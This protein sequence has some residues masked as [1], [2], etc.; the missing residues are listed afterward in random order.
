M[1]IGITAEWN[2]FHSGH[3][4]M[5]ASLASKYSG[6][7]KTAL[8][9]GA[10][11]QRGEPA[12]FDKWLRASWAVMAGVD[13]VIEFPV[14]GVLQS[15]DRFTDSAVQYL[16]HLGC[17]HI[18]FGTE[19]LDAHALEEAAD[20][21]LS[22]KYEGCFQ[23][24]LKK[25]L[26]YSSAAAQAMKAFSPALAK[27]LSRPNNLLGL[28]YA[29]SIR[30]RKYPIKLITVQRDTKHPIS[31]S[32]IRVA[33]LRH[34]TVTDLPDFCKGKTMAYM[35]EGR[36]AVPT[37]YDDACLLASRM[38][39]K[40][41]LLKSDIFSEGLENRWH[42]CRMSPTYRDMLS[43]IKSKRYL[44]SRLRRIGASLLLSSDMPSPFAKEPRITYARLLAFKASR[45]SLLKTYP[46]PVISNFPSFMKQ[47]SPEDKK[48][49][50]LEAKATDIQAFCMASP[51][52]REG[53]SDYYHP[54][55]RIL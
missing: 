18:A 40:A 21:L 53:G 4:Q 11:V 39:S 13:A 49:L 52:L 15:A 8:M 51:L 2:P 22:E 41:D 12:L 7:A 23:S 45:S 33:L 6:A 20:Y 44:Y 35:E 32:L 37:R 36:Y 19:S 10:F 5:I 24:N 38:L 42:A 29:V 9:S 50:L 43:Q 26:P 34:E 46:L 47:A 16:H 14:T 55:V 27:E 31:A 30:K 1:H 25:G 54:P 28:G 48:Q 17:T 3:L